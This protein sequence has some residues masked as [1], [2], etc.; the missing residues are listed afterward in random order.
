MC[1]LGCFVSFNYFCV[2]TTI[3]ISANMIM[4]PSH[5]Y[6]LSKEPTSHFLKCLPLG[7]NKICTLGCNLEIH[8]NFFNKF[9]CLFYVPLFRT[10]SL[11]AIKALKIAPTQW[12][13][14]TN[15]SF[16][17]QALFLGTSSWLY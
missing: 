9:L 13:V 7:A 2:W 14:G 1:H 16:V 4:H 12:L 3:A 10:I 5:L 8:S 11:K 6:T 17:F 15:F